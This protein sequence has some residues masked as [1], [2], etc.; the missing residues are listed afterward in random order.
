MTKFAEALNQGVV[1]F[2]IFCIFL[3]IIASMGFYFYQKIKKQTGNKFLASIIVAVFAAFAY[4]AYPTSAQKKPSGKESIKFLQTDAEIK[5]LIDAGSWVSNNTVHLE[6]QTRLLPPSAMLYLDYISKSEPVDSN[7]YTTYISG[8]VE[9]L[10]TLAY[11]DLNVIEFE[12]EN[13]IDNRWVFYTTYTPGPAVH[14][15]GVAVA[16]FI[17]AKNYEN[18]AVPKRSTIWEDGKKIYPSAEK[19]N[20]LEEIGADDDDN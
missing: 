6:Y 11:A 8:T 10:T 16:E 17:K 20:L 2:G 9:Q 4:T 3:C 14:T 19:I 1:T 12:F 5:Y 13:A 7:N 15:N 18:V